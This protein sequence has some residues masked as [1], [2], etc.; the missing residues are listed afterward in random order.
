MNVPITCRQ[1]ISFIADY[2]GGEVTEDERATF[3]R[4]LESCRSCRAYLASYRRTIHLSREAL[5]TPLAD[6][7]EELVNAILSRVP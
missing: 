5:E 6:V 3:E 2:L 4:H 7:P 1:L